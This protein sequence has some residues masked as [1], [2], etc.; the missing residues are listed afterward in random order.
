M[1]DNKNQET[2]IIK[3]VKTYGSGEQVFRLPSELAKEV[4]EIAESTHKTNKEVLSE[5]VSWA[6]ERCEIQ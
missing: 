5:L 4:I 3:K 6:L 1:S 2:L